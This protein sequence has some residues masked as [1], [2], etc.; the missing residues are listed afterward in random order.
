MATL[1]NMTITYSLLVEKGG[2]HNFGFI[3]QFTLRVYD[4]AKRVSPTCVSTAMM[5][6]AADQ[7]HR[8]SRILRIREQHRQKQAGKFHPE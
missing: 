1:H 5:L 6:T 2:G 7:I 4:H 8:N 3:T